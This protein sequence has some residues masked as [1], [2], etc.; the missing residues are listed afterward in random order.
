MASVG[1]IARRSFLIG[2][3]AVAGG[4]AF[5][6]YAWRKPVDNP[7]LADLPEGATTLNPYVMIDADGVTLITPRSDVGQG[8]VS[9]QTYLLAEEL[10]VDP[11]TVRTSFGPASGAY[12]NGKVAAEGMPFA[13][14]NDGLVSRV[15]R[16]AAGPA[17]KFLGLHITG[18]ST[19]VPD[20]YDRLRAA[21]ATA[22]E[23]L[24]QAA[25]N[26]YAFV[27]ADLRTEGGAV[28]LPTGD[29]VPYADLA[30]EAAALD[31]IEVAP[32]AAEGWKWLGK[33][34][35][36]TD[37]VAKSTG[38][39]RYGGDLVLDDMIH[40]TVVTNPAMDGGVV[41]VDDAAAR[42][43]RGVEDVVPI[44][45]GFAVLADNTWRAMAAARAL[46]I[47]WDVPTGRP[48]DSDAMWEAHTAAFIDDAQDSRFADDGDVDAAPG[49]L[50]T[51]EYRAPF[52]HH[53]PLEPANATVLYTEG[54]TQVWTATQVPIFVRDAVAAI[55][56]Q[57]ADLVQVHN[58]PSG[59]SF[60]HRL[61]YLWVQQAAE[62]AVQV[63][64]RPV[65]LTLSRE[66]D[67]THG[68]LRPMA[69]ARGRG[70][71]DDGQVRSLDLS[72]AAHSVTES[73]IGRAGLPAVGPDVAIVAAAWD[74]PYA[75][76][77]RR[78]TGYRVPAGVGVSS[79][80]SVG[81]SHNGFFIESLLDE[82]IAEAGADPVAERLR[83]LHDDAS[84]GVLEA[85]ADMAS[86]NGPLGDGKGRGVAFTIAFGVPCAQIIEVSDTE[87]GIRLDKLWIAADVGQ[88]LDPVNLES[89]LSGGALFG[90]GHA[91]HAEVTFDNHRIQQTNY[92]EY[93]S[94]RL[95]QTPQ[96]EVRTLET[97]PTIRGAGEPGLPPAAPALANAIFAATGTRLRDMP[98]AK[99]VRFA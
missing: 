9:I 97:L 38:T 37:M 28:I 55:T 95:W 69:I 20:M 66:Q 39:F 47:E 51:A 24:K 45:D 56:G 30:Q 42:A 49:D 75:I 79:W 16:S 81:A 71:V 65:R 50:V 92:H 18:G 74:A 54:G 14:W 52:L 61:D 13:A 43:M 1:K 25:A 76:P 6:V 83:L 96:V 29:A 85:V 4:V 87:A 23:T 7:L 22:R 48:A 34:M 78:I 68:F 12:Y 72:I 73:Q 17:A 32:R 94:M 3:A 33:N 77:D 10:D 88:V 2:S 98:F 21:G 40:A 60:G 82:L 63:P 27:R 15:G 80:R 26:R 99:S 62:I 70:T 11:Q 44:T 5:G 67:M 8:A 90:L 46:A 64:G 93:E 57:D 58:Q 41:S 59:G 36:R 91:M 86:W 84:R 19:T 89:Q 35:R 53:A 31:P